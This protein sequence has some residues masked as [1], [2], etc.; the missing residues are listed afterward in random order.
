MKV[1]V[2]GGGSTYTPELVSGLSR[3]DV[4][5]FV[6]HDIDPERREVAPAG[7]CRARLPT[8]GWVYR[9]G[10]SEDGQAEPIGL[11][12]PRPARSVL[13]P[14]LSDSRPAGRAGRWLEG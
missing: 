9:V 5:E 1:A 14:T 6:L 10:Y 2:V 3:L 13:H 11:T 8:L 7:A 4:S 12:D